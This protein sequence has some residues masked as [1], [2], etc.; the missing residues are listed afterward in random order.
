MRKEGFY[1]NENEMLELLSDKY[2]LQKVMDTNLKTKKYGLVLTAEDAKILVER[3]KEDLKEQQRIEFGEGI[4]PKLIFTFCDS[5]YIYQDNYVDT[6]IRLQ[7]IFYSYK[8]EVMN[9]LTDDELLDFM[10]NAFDGECKGSLEYLEETALE[11]YARNVRKEGK[12]F[13]GKY[14]KIKGRGYADDEL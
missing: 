3:R 4:L 14:Y 1:M 13:F 6:I 5:P 8:N 10:K 9:E 7:E 12:N 11:Q 2:Q